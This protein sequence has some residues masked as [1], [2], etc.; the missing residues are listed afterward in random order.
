VPCLTDAHRV[1][2]ILV[3]LLTNAVRH[4]PNGGPV[5]VRAE[6]DTT[7]V[8]I[9][10]EDRGPGIAPNRLDRI[11]DVYYGGKDGGPGI[12]LGLPLSRRLA[13]LLG[14]ELDAANRVE[15]GA[16]FTLTLP[17]AGPS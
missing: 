17:L 15:G 10:V 6:A 4:S 2:Q 9:V 7:T 8:R 12:G 3:N 16:T 5:D 13:R 14:G 11:F 1:E